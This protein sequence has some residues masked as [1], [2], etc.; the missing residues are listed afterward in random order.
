VLSSGGVVKAF[1]VKEG[2]TFSRKDLDGFSAFVSDF[3]AKGVMWARKTDEGWKSPMAKFLSEDQIQGISQRL[4]MSSG[5]LALFV[6]DTGETANAT[7]SA[8]RLH[9]A[10]RLDLIPHNTFSA[11]WVTAFPLLK[12]N[13]EDKR[14]T[15]V[16]HPFTAP[17]AADLDL[18]ETSPKQVKS[19]AYDMVINGNEVG[20]GSIRIHTPEVQERVFKAIGLGEEAAQTK[21]GFLLEALKYGAPPHGGIAFGMDRLIMILSHT[22]SI[23]DVIAFPKTASAYCLMTDAPSDVTD[24]Q[25]DEIGVKRK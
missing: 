10:Q 16:H 22:S 7:L 25:L 23:R 8:L 2:N 14:Y 15:S 11:L 19:Q 18:I 9:V 6:A 24:K 12:W 13:E 20:G 17:V 5:D 4:E 3:G 1:T 21:F